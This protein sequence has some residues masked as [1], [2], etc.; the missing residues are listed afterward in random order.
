[1]PDGDMQRFSLGA[2]AP[3]LNPHDIEQIH[4][5]WLKR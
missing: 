3:A 4:L 2:S 1:M 5:L